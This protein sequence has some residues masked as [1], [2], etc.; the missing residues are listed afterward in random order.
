MDAGGQEGKLAGGN[1]RMEWRTAVT[2]RME[3]DRHPNTQ[4]MGTTIFCGNPIVISR[5]IPLVI[6]IVLIIQYHACG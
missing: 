6:S 5:G 3:L 2:G 4:I 1:D